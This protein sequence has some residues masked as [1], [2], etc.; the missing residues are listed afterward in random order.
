MQETDQNS[1]VELDTRFYID[2]LKTISP[3]RTRASEAQSQ[4]KQDTLTYGHS[5]PYHS[6]AFPIQVFL[7]LPPCLAFCFHASLVVTM[8]LTCI[9]EQ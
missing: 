2:S 4:L 8:K 6:Q 7:P 5:S 9:S 3:T 1:I